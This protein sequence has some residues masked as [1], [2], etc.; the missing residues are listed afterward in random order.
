[1][2]YLHFL[3]TGNVIG[4]HTNRIQEVQGKMTKGKNGEKLEY[5]PHSNKGH[6][7]TLV[8]RELMPWE[9]AVIAK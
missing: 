7:I 8:R 1:M 3:Y 9:R 2:F 4:L 6:A 5:M